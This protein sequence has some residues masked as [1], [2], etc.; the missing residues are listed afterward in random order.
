MVPN[1]ELGH[2]VLV[3]ADFSAQE[4]LAAAIIAN[5]E[6]LLQA[7]KDGKDMHTV[8]ASMAFGLPEDE[9]PKD[10]RKQAKAVTFG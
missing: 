8:V 9:I 7:F 1:Y 4:V 5:D 3:L 10:L 2:D 6:T